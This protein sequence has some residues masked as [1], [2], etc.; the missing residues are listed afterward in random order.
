MT[1]GVEFGSFLRATITEIDRG[2]TLS[3]WESDAAHAI[4]H[5]WLTDCNSLYTYLNNPSTNGSEDKRLEI[6][7]ES[8]REP[9]WTYSDGRPKDHL[10]EDRTD[11]VRWIDTSTMIVDPLT[12]NGGRGFEDRLVKTYT[13]GYF[14]LVP[15][16]ESQMRKLKA[17]KH[18]K[19]KASKTANVDGDPE[20]V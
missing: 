9:L 6:D 1:Y 20:D 5:L 10:D 13:Q 4:K 2:I 18:R 17:S 15:T 3:R 7:L 16:A 14:D 12:K 11:E 19:G 8:L